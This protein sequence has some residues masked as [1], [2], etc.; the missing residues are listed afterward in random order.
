MTN[1]LS[2]L[3]Y[4]AGREKDFIAAIEQQEKYLANFNPDKTKELIA[5]LQGAL[6]FTREILA[7]AKPLANAGDTL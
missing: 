6:E 5:K 3:D 2:I 1:E 7:A 4:L